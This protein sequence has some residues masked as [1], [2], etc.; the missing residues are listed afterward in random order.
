MA[1]WIWF[2]LDDTLY[3]FKASSLMALRGIYVKYGLERYFRDQNEWIN[4][5][6][7]HNTHLWEL[8]NKADITQRQLRHDR[9]YLPLKDAGVPEDENNR[10]NDPLDHDYLELLGATG[11]LIPGALEAVSHLKNLGYYIGILS[12]GFKGVQHDKLK[13]SGLD[14]LVD[15]MILSDDININKP[16]RRIYDYALRKS[17]CAPSDALMIGD[18]PVTDIAGAI[19]AGW[20]ALLFAPG[21]EN[22]TITISDREIPVLH[23]LSE[24]LI[25]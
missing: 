19:N 22:R 18:N 13:S 24:L 10:L 3:D 1:K 5:Y 21:H 23:S 16:D 2:D 4:L 25:W 6:H 11:L 12:N 9:F 8:Y 7:R 20:D 14:K 15:M 17:N